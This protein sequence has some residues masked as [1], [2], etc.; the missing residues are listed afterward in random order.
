MTTISYY[1][2]LNEIF[3]K[4]HSIFVWPVLLIGMFVFPRSQAQG[5]IK[6]N[7]QNSELHEVIKNTS[8]IIDLPEDKNYCTELTFGDS[9][10]TDSFIYNGERHS[11]EH[12]YQILSEPNQSSNSKK[13]ILK[14]KSKKEPEFEI[15]NVSDTKLILKNLKTGVIID[16]KKK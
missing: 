4:T 14:I 8:W 10:F 2:A 12:L 6:S 11:R 5:T 16:C 13:Y 1:Q 7:V 15:I 3:M 9:I